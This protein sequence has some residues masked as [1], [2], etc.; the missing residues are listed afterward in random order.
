MKKSIYTSFDQMPLM[1]TVAE[2]SQFLGISLA[3]TYELVRSEGFP[4]LKI[5]SRIII[6]KEKFITWIDQKTSEDSVDLG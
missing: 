4:K 6:P 5:G 3:G 2:V 1:L